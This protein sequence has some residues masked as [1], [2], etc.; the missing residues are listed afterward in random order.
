[1]IKCN[2]IRSRILRY[3]TYYMFKID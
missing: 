1:M 3:F 2:C